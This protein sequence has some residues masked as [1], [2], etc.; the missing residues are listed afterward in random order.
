MGRAG[1]AS[2]AERERP[3]GPW[4]RAALLALLVL[5]A[6]ACERSERKNDGAAPG[7]ASAAPAVA[8]ADPYA[9]GQRLAAARTQVAARFRNVELPDCTPLLAEEKDR[10]LCQAS[11][12][13]L[14]TLLMALEREASPMQVTPLV[15]SAALSAQRASQAL[16]AAGM[17]R[18]LDERA[19]APEASA[20]ASASANANANAPPPQPAE[21]EHDHAHGPGASRTPVRSQENRD[22][23]A[24]GAYARVA[25]LGLRELGTI[26]EFGPLTLRQHAFIE[27][28]RLAREEPQWAGLRVLVQEAQLVEPD[29]EQKQRL[30]KLRQRLGP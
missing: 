12:R 8:T 10:E 4:P 18:L 9:D 16:R 5:V 7:S 30:S 6:C 14:T 1:V 20:S 19:R 26:L 24:I 21:R 29:P 28:E 22:L 17:R 15:G 25:T 3:R 2:T 23:D 11:R 27:L 13:D